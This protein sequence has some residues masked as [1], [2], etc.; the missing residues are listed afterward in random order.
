[1][2]TKYTRDGSARVKNPFTCWIDDVHFV[3]DAPPSASVAPKACTTN[4]ANARARRLHHG[5]Q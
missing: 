3:K 5:Q 1:M 2:N 4:A